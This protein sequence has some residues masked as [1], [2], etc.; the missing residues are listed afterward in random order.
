[1]NNQPVINDDDAFENGY[2][3]D[4]IAFILLS[5]G[6]FLFFCIFLINKI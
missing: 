3:R 4:G 2:E 1:M 5:Y 6:N